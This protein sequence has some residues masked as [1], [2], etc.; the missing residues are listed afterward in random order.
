MLIDIKTIFNE[1]HSVSSTFASS[2]LPVSTTNRAQE[3]NQVF[4]PMFRP[5][6]NAYPRWMGNMKQYQLINVGTSVELGD[7]SSLPISALN[8]SSGLPTDCAVSFWTTPSGSYW[9]N[10]IEI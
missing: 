1:I 7:N 2:S 10:V 8:N 4:I 5:D 6:P 9:E 3:K